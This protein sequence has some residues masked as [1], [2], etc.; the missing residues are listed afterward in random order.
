MDHTDCPFCQPLPPDR[1]LAP[2]ESFVAFFDEFPVTPGHA[3]V[4]PKRHVASLFN[5]PEPEYREL[6]AQVSEVRKRLAEKFHTAAF[7]YALL[8]APAHMGALYRMRKTICYGS[9]LCRRLI[10]GE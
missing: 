7:M 10:T 8:M 4:I 2:S 6:W 5:L 1:V 9:S 3:L